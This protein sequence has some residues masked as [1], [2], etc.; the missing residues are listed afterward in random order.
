MPYFAADEAQTLDGIF[1]N[2]A[3]AIEG[4]SSFHIQT[5]TLLNQ[6]FFISAATAEFIRTKKSLMAHKFSDHSFL[7]LT[8]T[9]VSAVSTRALNGVPSHLN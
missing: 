6:L 2:N 5:L 9:I 8:L 7:C 1:W 4:V 3:G